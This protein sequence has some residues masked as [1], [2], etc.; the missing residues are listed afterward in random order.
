MFNYPLVM[1]CLL[2]VVEMAFWFSK[3]SNL[4]VYA[5]ALAIE[6]GLLVLW[7]AAFE[8]SWYVW[9]IIIVAAYRVINLW[10]IV[11]NR[12]Q[13]DHTRQVT[14]RSS[15]RLLGAQ[16]LTIYLYI[17]SPQF[18]SA[19]LAVMTGLMLAGSIVLAAAT[20]RNLKTTR[21]DRTA[22]GISDDDL[23]TVSVLVPARDE[24]EDLYECLASLVRS[25]YPKLEII[26]LDDRSQ[27]KRT[28]EIIKQFASDG[29]SFIAGG[30]APPS[31]LAKN[32]AYQQLVDASSGELLLFC[33]VDTRFQPQT[34]E[35]M[36]TSLVRKKKTMISFIPGNA[37]PAALAFGSILVQPSR[38]A[39]ELALPR[40][41]LQ[42]PPVLTSAWLISRNVLQAAGGFAAF[43]RAI[44][45]ERY[46]ARYAAVHDD[47]YSF[48]QSDTN[49]GVS[50]AKSFSEQRATAV[51][52]RYPQLHQSLE[53][54][55]LTS[56]SELFLLVGPFI[57]SGWSLWNRQWLI[58]TLAGLAATLLIIMYIQIVNLT[59][60]RLV[61][62]S[63]WLLPLAAVYDVIL[64]NYSMFKYEFSEVQ[65]KGRD[66]S[67]P[68][69]QV[70]DRLPKA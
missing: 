56:V 9:P 27:N 10:R 46:L 37:A 42:R 11:A 65:W 14:R 68:A 55:A 12:R 30:L 20:Q 5:A 54:T 23:P 59:Y 50:S 48:M 34:I 16:A 36:V 17:I 33:G 70:I 44:I 2:L 63:F 66:I 6:T 7:L 51:R 60:R 3:K 31:W 58:F 24:T 52:T 67:I 29:V 47:G 32:H 4:R 38:Y 22:D 40:R 41:S 62:R 45:P 13:P 61:L 18:T 28:P 69:M 35:Q 25:T 39:W 64:L 53:L 1:F 26:V 43:S 21:P 57:M 8:F 15:F 19:G 49:S